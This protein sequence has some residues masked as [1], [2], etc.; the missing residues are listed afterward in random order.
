M[1][2][3]IVILATIVVTSA[4]AGMITEIPTSVQAPGPQIPGMFDLGDL[5]ARI[6]QELRQSTAVMPGMPTRMPIVDE[7]GKVKGTA[8]I[9]GDRVYLRD[10]DEQLI[11]TVVVDRIGRRKMYDPAGKEIQSLDWPKP[12]E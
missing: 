2:A 6:Q 4:N 1:K 11:A 8:T 7:T 10:K 9:A 3:L 12:A 5:Q